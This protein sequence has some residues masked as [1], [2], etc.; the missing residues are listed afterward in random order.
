[1][2]LCFFFLYIFTESQNN[3]DFN[4]VVVAIVQIYVCLRKCKGVKVFLKKIC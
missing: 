2:F 4:T 3:N 1:M